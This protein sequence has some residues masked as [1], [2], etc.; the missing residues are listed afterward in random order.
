MRLNLLLDGLAA[1]S[2]EPIHLHIQ[3]PGGELLPAL[4]TADLIAA[5]PAPVY[6]YI[7][8]FAASAAT[9]L[10]VVGSKRFITPHSTM[11]LHQLSSS[12]AGT[13][14]QLQQSSRNDALLMKHVTNLYLQH[15]TF[16]L[17]QLTDLLSRD[18]YLSAQKCLKH[19]VVDVVR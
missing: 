10:S 13:F 9:L 8:G 16:S 19:R 18:E 1:E 14:D 6:T 12:H 15:T 17:A 4:Y 5:S 3:S 11:L 7:D 2:S